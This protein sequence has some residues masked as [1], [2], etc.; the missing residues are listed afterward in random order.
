MTLDSTGVGV[1][2]VDIWKQVIPNRGFREFTFSPETPYVIGFSAQVQ[3]EGT[4]INPVIHWG[5]ALGTGVIAG[6]M[7][8]NPPAQPIFHQNGETT[9]LSIDDL[10]EQRVQEGSAGIGI[11]LDNGHRGRHTAIVI[12]HRHRYRVR[13]RTIRNEVER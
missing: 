6:G 9:R 10:P 11:D 2:L 4:A 8:Y 5:P 3:R 13:S 7:T 12:V 1:A